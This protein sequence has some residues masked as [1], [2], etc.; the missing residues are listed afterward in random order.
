[1]IEKKKEFYIKN[2]LKEI[3]KFNPEKLYK[4]LDNH[5]IKNMPEKWCLK[6]CLK[7]IKI[8]I[9]EELEKWNWYTIDIIDY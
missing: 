4:I 2:Y 5:K 1:M 6:E 7:N 3:Y 9:K 8:L